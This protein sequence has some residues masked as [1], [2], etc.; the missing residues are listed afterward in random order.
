MAPEPFRS[1]I[2]EKLQ[3]QRPPGLAKPEDGECFAS[4]RLVA[5]WRRFGLSTGPGTVPTGAVCLCIS[6]SAPRPECG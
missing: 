5:D 4:G 2:A 6:V 1:G 3:K